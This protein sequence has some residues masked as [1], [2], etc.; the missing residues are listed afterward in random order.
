M[1]FRYKEEGGHPQSIRVEGRFL[2]CYLFFLFPVFLFYQP[3]S[4]V[5]QETASPEKDSDRTSGDASG[6]PSSK[7]QPSDDEP[8]THEQAQPKLTPPRLT[9][10]VQATYPADAEGKGLQAQVELEI[11]IAADGLVSD[12]QVITEVGNGFDEAA[13]E[14][15]KG[16]VFEPAKRDG[17]PVPSRIRYSY[18]FEIQQVVEEVEPLPS[19]EPQLARLEGR[20]LNNQDDGPVEG[21]EVLISLQDGSIS[22]RKVTDGKGFFEFQ[23]LPEGTYKLNLFAEKFNPLEA[24]EQ[25]LAN[26]VTEVVYRLQRE[27]DPYAFSATARIP[28]PPR[29][30]T[31][32]TINRQQLTRIAGTR[33][34]PIRTVE[35]LPGVAR[36]PFG[37]GQ[38]VVRGSRPS[39]TEPLFEGLPI[40]LLYHFGGLT[41]FVN[42]RLLDSIDFYPGNFSVRY[43]RKQGGIVEVRAA[44]PKLDA[45]HG[46]AD[47]N[48]V[49]A[50]LFLEIPVWD[51][52]GIMAAARRSYVDFLFES[53]FS[54]DMFSVVA[55]PVYWD[56]QLL[57]TARV[58][59]RDRLR[60]MGYGSRDAF[61]V[62]FQQP[63]GGQSEVTGNLDFSYLSHRVHGTWRRRVSKSIDQ[64]VE[65]AVGERE[66]H[67]GF[68]EDVDFRFGLTEV[69]ARSEWR[70]R[71]SP[72]V[73]LIG[74]LDLFSGPGEVRY[75]GPR[76]GQRMSGR[77]QQG[78]ANPLDEIETVDLVQKFTLFY[79]AV[80]L[81]SDIY[82]RPF[83]LVL[84]TRL[85]Y[86]NIIDRFSF[87]P[88][89]S[90]HYELTEEVTLKAGIGLFSQPPEGQEVA[91][92]LGNPNLKPNRA[93]HVSTGCEY[94]PFEGIKFGLEGYFKHLFQ[95]VV[96]TA[97]GVE[98]YYIN[99]G[100]GR[101]YGLE[102]SATVEP[103][104]RFFGYLS[105]TLSRS[106]RKN[107]DES[108]ALFGY[109]QPHILTASATYRL[110][111]GWEVGGTFRLVSGN[112]FTPNEK[113]IYEANYNY[114]IP[115]RGESNSRR[116]RL[117]HR[118]DVRIEKVWTFT[119]WK[120]SLYLDV[121]NA[122]NAANQEGLIYDFRYEQS[123]VLTGL[124]ILPVL[125]IRGEL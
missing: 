53:F 95:Q 122:Y 32:R 25:V 120:L 56:Y 107:R 114:Y 85:D 40:P 106:E 29:E 119:D 1:N 14:A 109:D 69:D 24:Q 11:T 94:Q 20:I 17:V 38:L 108:W 39:D 36:P 60:I 105:Y 64:D 111:R 35:I 6:P 74:G 101:I 75:L 46:V 27:D 104:G 2:L 48:L 37:S 4:L 80:Y 72:I 61:R 97:Y 121:Q 55:A 62:L 12:V 103:R 65:L 22:R 88:R 113:G 33:G 100:I 7:A 93:L 116:S 81:E 124:P 9:H 99:D 73:R 44:D 23:E 16:F 118:L 42:P 34:D 28:P 13:V 3:Q 70:Y 83:R 21:V 89:L 5:A 30:V 78:D 102:F 58:S 112:P 41:S 110:G 77:G 68:G 92:E 31:R 84:G 52:A 123:Q 15:A 51:Q 91:N 19:G 90:T 45:I 18:I 86:Y 63:S 59:S 43:G 54:D 115:I 49:D 26:Q 76:P 87:D 66:L 98:P 71:V 117:F 47:I 96:M 79:P 57:G 8:S 10:F 67:V 82:L 125:G 50:S